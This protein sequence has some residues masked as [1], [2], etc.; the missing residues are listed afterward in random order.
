M[1]GKAW[2]PRTST[3]ASDEAAAAGFDAD[4]EEGGGIAKEAGAAG[5]LAAGFA[6][7]AGGGRSFTA[8]YS[9]L[10]LHRIFSF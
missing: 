2:P 7:G 10:I 9:S 6:A 8:A 5:A 3:D 4:A 1:A